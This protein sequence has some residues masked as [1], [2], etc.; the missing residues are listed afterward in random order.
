MQLAIKED[1]TLY[2]EDEIYE[3]LKMYARDAKEQ[4]KNKEIFGSIKEDEYGEITFID[5]S[6]DAIAFG[7]R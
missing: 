4:Q 3:F 2:T 7:R 1:N 5:D 6:L